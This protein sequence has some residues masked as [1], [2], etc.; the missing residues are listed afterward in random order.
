M[1]DEELIQ[2]FNDNV[3]CTETSVFHSKYELE[4]TYGEG[5]FSHITDFHGVGWETWPL[6]EITVDC[7]SVDPYYI[8][9][10]KPLTEIEIAVDALQSNATD[11]QVR[12]LIS[13]NSIEDARKMFPLL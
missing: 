10:E 7:K 12:N 11:L 9:S 5:H 13:F 2:L 3:K 8:W 4:E 6:Y 1:G